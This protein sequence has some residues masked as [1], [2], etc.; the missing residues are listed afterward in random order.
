MSED[1]IRVSIRVNFPLKQR[2]DKVFKWGEFNNTMVEI[3][4]WICDMHDKHGDQAFLLFRSGDLSKFFNK[5]G[6]TK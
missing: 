1:R 3:L 2:M 5:E 6:L 4:Q